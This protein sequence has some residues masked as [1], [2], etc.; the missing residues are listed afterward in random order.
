MV[1]GTAVGGMVVGGSAV[2]G[3][4]VGGS[5]VGMGGLVAVDV[6]AGLDVAGNG[7]AVTMTAGTA[8]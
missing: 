5:P 3:S 6:R 8:V 7:V 1:G 2:G 4:V